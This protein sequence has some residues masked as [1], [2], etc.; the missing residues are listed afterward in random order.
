METRKS[1]RKEIDDL[2][3]GVDEDKLFLP[4]R[5]FTRLVTETKV[6]EL[7]PSASSA[8]VNFVCNE[9][10]RIFLIL[11]FGTFVFDAPEKEVVSVIDQFRK[12]Q[13]NDK[14]L[15]IEDITGRCKAEAFCSR[16]RGA[17]KIGNRECVH[18]AALNV[19]HDER[20]DS[21][22]FKH[23]RQTQWTFSAPVFRKNDFKQ[24]LSAGVVLPLTWA[25]E[26]PREGHF[27]KVY[28]ATLHADHQDEFV[29]D[30]KDVHVAVKELNTLPGDKGYNVETAW[31]L[32]AEALEQISQL[33]HRHL[34]RRLAA[35]KRGSQYFIMFEWAKGG[36]LR[37][38][39]EHNAAEHLDLNGDK[40]M[41]LL[42]QLL[43]LAG[44]LCALHNTN[45]NTKTAAATKTSN[46]RI[47]EK[48]NVWP[49]AEGFT[50][51]KRDVK[52]VII[53]VD[54]PSEENYDHDDDD[55]DNYD[56]DDSDISS[57]DEHWRHG[58][59]KPD[60]ILKFDGSTCLG[61][62]KIADLGLA[63][64]HK[65]KTADRHDP[66]K[67]R[68]ATEQYEAP[69][70]ITN[71]SQPRSRRYDVWSMG[72]IIFECVIW[73]LYGYNGLKTFYKE[74]NY[75]DTSTET[76]YF[77]ANKSQGIATVSD[78]VTSWLDQILKDDPECNQP[79]GTALGDL[80]KL[81]RDKLLIVDLP[82]SNMSPEALEQ[83]RAESDTLKT[84]LERIWKDARD[85]DTYL[86]TGT[87]REGVPKPKLL[88]GKKV[89]NLSPNTVSGARLVSRNMNVR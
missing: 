20:W 22:K 19:F 60:N 87:S 55:D 68:Y 15:P 47:E 8:L 44:A 12:H 11:I 54:S 28:E 64:Q 34:I 84:G 85:R 75:I 66:T 4:D 61:T 41:G 32:E 83:C 63:K 27:S 33:Q 37:D 88:G 58:D 23:F 73:L 42:E 5:Y 35:F 80:L 46:K 9:A 89:V 26:N 1:F 79:G 14:L 59:L 62:L 6:I 40:I 2:L 43:G 72:C 25:S 70:V 36:T 81:V 49:S 57:G 77:T 51:V 18:D 82:E 31:N 24:E 21:F 48:S 56:S 69:E 29:T 13:L 86:F 17:Q 52:T 45:S 67:Q 74:K 71:F 3:V 50:N 53:K 16:R 10:K 7:L 39:W 30:G 76:L 78:I 38:V 65:Y